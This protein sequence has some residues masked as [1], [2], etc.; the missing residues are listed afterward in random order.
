M[1]KRNG[2][3]LSLVIDRENASAYPAFMNY[4]S[5]ILD[6]VSQIAENQLFALS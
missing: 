1:R 2:S 3:L 4:L 5:L 6:R